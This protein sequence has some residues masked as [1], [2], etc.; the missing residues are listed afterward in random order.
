M[1]RRVKWAGQAERTLEQTTCGLKVVATTE[2]CD[3]K[4]LCA[5]DPF[6]SAATHMTD[7]DESFASLQAHLQIISMGIL[8]TPSCIWHHDIPENTT[9]REKRGVNL[10]SRKSWTVCRSSTL[11]HESGCFSLNFSHEILLKNLP[12]TSFHGDAHTPFWICT[13]TLQ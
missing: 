4:T 11:A 12:W 13:F 3:I 8:V 7:W 6:K 1:E 10:I 9:Q 2:P 5:R